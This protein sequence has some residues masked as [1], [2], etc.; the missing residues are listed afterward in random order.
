[1]SENE[2]PRIGIAYAAEGEN[3]VKRRLFERIRSWGDLVLLDPERR[4][5]NLPEMGLDLYHMARWSPAAYDDFESARDAGVPTVNSY[6]GARITEDRVASARACVDAG[7]PFVEFEFGT[8]RE[9]TL[10]PPVL[11][12]SRHELDADGHDFQRVFRGE[13]AFEGERMVERYI[14]PSRS[15]KVFNVGEHV[16]ATER[17]SEDSDWEQV[18]P[19]GRFVQL[20][21]GV[22]ALFDLRL[23][24]LDVLVHKTYYIID[25]NPVV[26][27]EG[28]EDAVD[29]YEELLRTRLEAA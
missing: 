11:V 25:V 24:E 15:F 22:A 16:R 2:S 7:L 3:P 4:H 12:K 29:L 19:S 17:I 23:F 10:E 28:V 9:I 1:M 6:E 13:I 27:L 8:A 14:V 20:A 26:S 21:E 5:P 18:D